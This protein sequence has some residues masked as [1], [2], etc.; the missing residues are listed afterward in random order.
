[1]L[2]SLLAAKERAIVVVER[3]ITRF[4]EQGDSVRRQALLSLRCEELFNDITCELELP[5]SQSAILIS[6]SFL[7]LSSGG[8][9]R[10]EPDSLASELGGRVGRVAAARAM[11]TGCVEQEGKEQKE[12]VSD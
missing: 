7:A 8:A 10:G 2:N 12:A 5:Y 4:D 6:N 11:E 9:D 3:S 1:M